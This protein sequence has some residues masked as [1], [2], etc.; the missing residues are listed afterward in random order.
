MLDLTRIFVSFLIFGVI[1]VAIDFLWLKLTSHFYQQKLEGLLRVR[2]NIWAAVAFYSL[3]S[4]GVVYFVPIWS[5]R[6]LGVLTVFVA[7]AVFGLVAY[8][9]YDL[10]NLAT[11]KKWSVRLTVIDMLWGAF[12]TSVAVLLTFLLVRRLWP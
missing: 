2:P 10:T 4:L 1:F 3:Y 8:G 6:S 5:N 9:V 12:V 7:G 11:L